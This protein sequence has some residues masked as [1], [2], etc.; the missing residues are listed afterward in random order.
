MGS[1][2]WDAYDTLTRIVT[3]TATGTEYTLMDGLTV[4]A[5]WFLS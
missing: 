3:W 5:R 1:S 2:L 4:V